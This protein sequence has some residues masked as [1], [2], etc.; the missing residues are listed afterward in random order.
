[1]SCYFSIG[2]VKTHKIDHDL[3]MGLHHKCYY[4]QINQSGME[5]MYIGRKNQGKTNHFFAQIMSNSS[6]ICVTLYVY[7]VE[8]CI[9]TATMTKVLNM[10]TAPEHNVSIV[11]CGAPRGT[12]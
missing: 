5:Q 1:M 6:D 10:S 12:P 9:L 4:A 11:L 7:L 3:K 2:V 8:L